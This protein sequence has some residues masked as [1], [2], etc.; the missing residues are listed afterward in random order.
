MMTPSV[1]SA[2]SA[3]PKRVSGSGSAG[4]TYCKFC[5]HTW[6][7]QKEYDRHLGCCEYF[8]HRRRNPTPEMDEH[9]TKIPT[10]RE[11]FRYVQD[12]SARL[13]KNEKEVVRLRQLVNSRQRKA[14]LEWLNQPSQLPACTFEDWWHQC[15]AGPDAVEKTIQRDLTQ[16]IVQCIQSHVAASVG[17]GAK[18]PIRCFTQKPGQFYV[19]SSERTSDLAVAATGSSAAAAA[20]TTNTSSL[21][22]QPVWR[23]MTNDQLER[24]A[25]HLSQSILRAFLTWSEQQQQAAKGDGFDPAD[26]DDRMMD[27]KVLLMMKVNG[28]GVS[29][30][31]R[32]VDIKKWLYPQLEENLRVIA[33]CE[34]E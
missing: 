22:R 15:R 27:K 3:S 24:M 32:L 12:L 16:G 17:S 6:K 21:I 5:H 7:L 30:E 10:G 19:Y 25:L 31:R 8:Y 28:N 11:L 23:A 1:V 33:S 29:I 2:A 18:L 4:G 20:E 14:I 9:G 13:E 26:V 34:F